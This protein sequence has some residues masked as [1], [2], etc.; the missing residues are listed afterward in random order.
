MPLEPDL[1]EILGDHRDAILG[2]LHVA[3]PGRV[4]TYDAAKQVADVVPCVRGTIPDS[5]GNVI[6][7]DL[8]V[9]P[10]VP[11]AW[12]RGGGFYLHFPLAVG[13][14]VWLVFNSSAIAQWRATGEVSEPGDLRRSSLSYPFAIPA[15]APDKQAFTDAPASG[16]AVIGVPSGGS[17]RI[18]EAGAPGQP[19]MTA[20]AF[21]IALAAA[22]IAVASAPVAVGAGGAS[23][24][25]TAFAG[26][27]SAAA[28]SS[29][30]L[31][32]QFP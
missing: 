18:S 17:L 21:L 19:V 12:P 13:D 31:K 4:Q 29:S 20:D 9:I 22:V 25:F 2:E 26:A 24:A 32:A 10:N 27:F 30:K 6:L 1:T 8:P 28:I 5:D 15:A 16:E 23:A 3:M 14:H 7:E 11:V